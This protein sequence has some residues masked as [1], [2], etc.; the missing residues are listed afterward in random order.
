LLVL[1]QQALLFI[2]MALLFLGPL[3]LLIALPQK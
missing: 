3:L 2:G 1:G